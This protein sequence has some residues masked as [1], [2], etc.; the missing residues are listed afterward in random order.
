MLHESLSMKKTT[1][2]KINCEIKLYWLNKLSY[3]IKYYTCKVSS[4]TK[5]WQKVPSWKFYEG[6]IVIHPW[7]ESCLSCLKNNYPKW[8]SFQT[9]YK[10]SD[11][12]K[13]RDFMEDCSSEEFH[14]VRKSWKYSPSSRHFGRSPDTKTHPWNYSIMIV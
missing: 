3:I 11:S 7:S 12:S 2:L 5:F 4:W 6:I 9:R 14:E 13:P 1:S 10:Y 8:I